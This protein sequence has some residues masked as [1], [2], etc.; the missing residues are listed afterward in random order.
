MTEQEM[1]EQANEQSILDDV[2]APQVVDLETPEVDDA[3]AKK[4]AEKADKALKAQQAKEAKAVAKAAKDAEKA[5]AKA[6][7]QKIKDDAKAAKEA[8]KTAPKVKEPKVILPTQN[9]V[10]LRAVGTSG[11]AIWGLIN[12]ISATKGELCKISEVVE[13]A[14]ARTYLNKLGQVT[15][16]NEGNISPEFAAYKKY[17]GLVA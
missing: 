16:I 5:A 2:S 9:G 10:R 4:E 12:E 3:A 1:Q 15:N 11:N 8:E 7:A 6:A 13:L 17:H 14:V